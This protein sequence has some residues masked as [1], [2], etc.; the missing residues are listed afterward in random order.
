[1]DSYLRWAASQNK[2][3][4]SAEHQVQLKRGRVEMSH[5]QTGS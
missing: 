1:M 2:D 4:E 3:G 5:T